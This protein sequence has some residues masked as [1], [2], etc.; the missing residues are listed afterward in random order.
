MDKGE[1]K[2]KA[3]GMSGGHRGLFPW[4]KHWTLLSARRAVEKKSLKN[5]VIMQKI[6]RG[7]RK[8]VTERVDC[9]NFIKA[10]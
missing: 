10:V 6:G 1:L 3:W 2:L 4:L 9:D 7:E 5:L 8:V